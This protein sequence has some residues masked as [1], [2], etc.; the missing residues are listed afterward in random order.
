M[1]I[2][3]ATVI[4]KNGSQVI[5]LIGNACYSESVKKISVRLR[6]NERIITPIGHTW[7]HF[8]LNGPAVSDDFMEDLD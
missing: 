3:V 8:F 6:G 5:P 7:D 4:T 1:P 2:V